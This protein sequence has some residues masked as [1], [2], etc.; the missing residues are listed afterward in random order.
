MYVTGIPA[1]LMVDRRGPRLPIL[2]GALGMGLGYYPIW[3]AA[4][5][6]GERVGGEVRADVAGTGAVLWL[7]AC[8]VVTGAGSSFAFSGAL[9]T[10]KL[11][12]S[13]GR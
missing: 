2:L 4:R 6:A 7:G 9:K 1:G 5:E 12:L 10:G 3:V 11:F 8:M 13:A